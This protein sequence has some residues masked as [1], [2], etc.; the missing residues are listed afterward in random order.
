M[1]SHLKTLRWLRKQME[2]A[3]IVNTEYYF[4]DCVV[5]EEINTLEN[6]SCFTSNEMISFEC[7]AEE[8]KR[9]FVYRLRFIHCY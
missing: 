8:K 6:V 4:A 1:S 2:C 7:R 5:G 9:N 3:C